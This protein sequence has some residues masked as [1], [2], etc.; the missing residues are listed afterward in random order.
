MYCLNA[1]CD[2]EHALARHANRLADL[3]EAYVARIE[4]YR[5]N[6]SLVSFF[7]FLF[8]LVDIWVPQRR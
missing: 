2:S 4:R 5:L 1:L 6:S 3:R 7:D 8:N